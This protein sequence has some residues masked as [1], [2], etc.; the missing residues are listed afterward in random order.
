MCASCFTRVDAVVLNS[1]GLV[2]LAAAA[3]TRVLD[4]WRGRTRAQR[5]QA[6]Y[7]TTA[8]FL[9]SMGHDPELLL[10]PAPM[11]PAARPALTRD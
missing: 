1:A 2:A 6:D 11:A 10:G 7:D 8:D 4:A 3:R 5:R 9:R